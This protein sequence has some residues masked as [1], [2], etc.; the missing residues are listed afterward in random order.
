MNHHQSRTGMLQILTNI[1]FL[2]AIF[3]LF[4]S[5]LHAEIIELTNGNL[6]QGEILKRDESFI[7]L[8][9]KEESIVIKNDFI[10]KIHPDSELKRLERER[11]EK[12]KLERRDRLREK[13]REE[14]QR[15]SEKAAKGAKQA[16]YSLPNTPGW[17]LGRSAILPGW[18]QR[19]AGIAAGD[20]LIGAGIAGGV[21]VLYLNDVV[22]RA[23][24]EYERRIRE[25]I[26]LT[27]LPGSAGLG[28]RLATGYI[29][30]DLA[31]K[32][33]GVSVNRLTISRQIFGAFYAGQ[34]IHL[35]YRLGMSSLIGRFERPSFEIA[36][37]GVTSP[38][39]PVAGMEA[40]IIFR[41][42]LE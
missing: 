16:Q 21:A 33:C 12:E 34:L 2:A 23:H 17:V 9:T 27:L 18:G 22:G 31:G 6:M 29:L 35:A 32:D 37:S 25:N 3:A 24:D 1:I 10:R 11:A 36:L 5:P 26:L 38:E 14:I 42:S 28:T 19:E 7:I 20:G 15:S 41:I 39:M 40:A 30:N 4:H 8:R 13:V